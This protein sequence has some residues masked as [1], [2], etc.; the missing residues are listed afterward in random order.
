MLGL[1]SPNFHICHPDVQQ[2]LTY[3]VRYLVLLNTQPGH[4]LVSQDH[5]NAISQAAVRITEPRLKYQKS[6]TIGK[7][8][9]SVR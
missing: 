2:L 4:R 7:E 8:P 1:G 9:L 5:Y 3:V 6:T